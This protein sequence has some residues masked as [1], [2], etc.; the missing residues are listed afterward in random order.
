MYG[1]FIYAQFV[2]A[3][4]DMIRL[5]FTLSFLCSSFMCFAANSAMQA[6][7]CAPKGILNVVKEKLNPK[8][9]WVDQSINAENMLRFWLTGEG[10]RFDES[11]MIISD[12]ALLHQDDPIARQ[13]CV[14]YVRGEIEFWRRCGQHAKRMCRLY[15]GYC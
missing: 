6:S 12:C 14:T 1:G 2:Y 7:S 11:T 13:E 3:R 9:F 15:G 10:A 8:S 5:I 4:I